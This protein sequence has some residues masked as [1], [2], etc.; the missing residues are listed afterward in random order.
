M[1]TSILGYCNIIYMKSRSTERNMYKPKPNN[2]KKLEAFL[3][4]IENK[5]YNGELPKDIK[6]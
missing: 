6:R 5:D 4:K 2:V 1:L 3:S